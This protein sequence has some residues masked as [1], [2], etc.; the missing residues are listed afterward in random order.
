[1]V[2]MESIQKWKKQLERSRLET[3]LAWSEMVAQEPLQSAD[4]KQ[5]HKLFEL[6]GSLHSRFTDLA[7]Y[8]EQTAADMKA[9]QRIEQGD[10]S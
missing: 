9:R 1:M 2:S 7:L 4:I 10:E 5:L 8:R 3:H 6:L